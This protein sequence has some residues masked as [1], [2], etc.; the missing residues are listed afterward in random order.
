MVM[1]GEC[2]DGLAVVVMSGKLR[3]VGGKVAEAVEGT[4]GYETKAVVI[5]G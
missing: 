4:C 1:A 5:V 2:G 3:C